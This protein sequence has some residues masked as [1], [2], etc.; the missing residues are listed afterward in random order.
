M[1]PSTTVISQNSL[2][3]PNPESTFLEHNGFNHHSSFVEVEMTAV[4]SGGGGGGYTSLRDI[5]A[6]SSSSPPSI[7]SPTHN[8]SWDEI[9]IKNPL[10]KHAAL[11]YLQ[12]M[13]TPPEVGDRGLFGGLKEKCCGE[14]GCLEW[15]AAIVV[16]PFR[17]V[18]W[19]RSEEI[20]GADDDVKAE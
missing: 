2:P 8:S 3:N 19:E 11:A 9:P 14:C 6:A 1:E 12:P 15:L 16:K 7:V 5:L 20:D 18:I 4:Q 17:D 13:S 10:V